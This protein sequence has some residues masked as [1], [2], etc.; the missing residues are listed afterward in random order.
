MDNQSMPVQTKGWRSNILQGGERVAIRWF[1]VM[2][3]EQELGLTE[4]GEWVYALHEKLYPITGKHDLMPLFPLLEVPEAEFRTLLRTHLVALGL[5]METGDTF[6][7]D[8]IVA[9]AI[10]SCSTHWSSRALNWL[11]QGVAVNPAI[12]RA[13]SEFVQGKHGTHRDRLR[14]SRLLRRKG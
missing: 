14:A 7:L 5:P 8:S 10:D 1:G 13:L 11:E 3:L 2:V 12:A 9:G 4:E 6:P